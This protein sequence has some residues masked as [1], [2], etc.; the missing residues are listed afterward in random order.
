MNKTTKVGYAT[1]SENDGIDYRTIA[2]TMTH[3]GWK[4]NHSSARNYVL[5]VMKKFA[6]A[7]ADAWNIKVNSVKIEEIARSPTFQ[8]GICDVLNKITI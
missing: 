7:Y 3:V 4:M 2:E 1:I 5:R 8:D 6:E